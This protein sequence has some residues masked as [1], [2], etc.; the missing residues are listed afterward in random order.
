MLES[1]QWAC[2]RKSLRHAVKDWAK[3]LNGVLE[4]FPRRGNLLQITRAALEDPTPSRCVDLVAMMASLPHWERRQNPPHWKI[5][6]SILSSRFFPMVPKMEAET[7]AEPHLQCSKAEIRKRCVTAVS[8]Q[9]GVADDRSVRR[10][11]P[12]HVVIQ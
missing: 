1:R 8:G 5:R 7:R 2:D 4:N 10:A 12:G 3:E 6:P 9:E 11:G